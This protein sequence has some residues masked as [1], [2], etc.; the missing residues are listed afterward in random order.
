MKLKQEFFSGWSGMVFYTFKKSL[1]VFYFCQ[2]SV[3]FIPNFKMLL[4]SAR[5]HLEE[6]F[7]YLLFYASAGG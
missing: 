2:E 1:L 6:I 5:A 4:S 7:F 3:K